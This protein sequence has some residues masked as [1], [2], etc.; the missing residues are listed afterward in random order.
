MLAAAV[1]VCDDTLPP[2]SYPLGTALLSF[3]LGQLAQVIAV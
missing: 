2:P 1:D 3:S